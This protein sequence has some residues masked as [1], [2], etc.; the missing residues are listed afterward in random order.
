VSTAIV[1][2]EM[3]GIDK[4]HSKIRPSSEMRLFQTANWRTDIQHVTKPKRTFDPPFQLTPMTGPIP[5]WPEGIRRNEIAAQMTAT[6]TKGVS[7]RNAIA[8]GITVHHLLGRPEGFLGR[9]RISPKLAAFTP[10]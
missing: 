2:E 7:V 3:A 10:H 4:G 1:N 8:L 9:G 5:Q 6:K